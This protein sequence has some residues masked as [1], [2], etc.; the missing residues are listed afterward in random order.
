MEGRLEYGENKTHLK[1]SEK[2]EWYVNRLDDFH[3]YEYDFNLWQEYT[4][5]WFEQESEPMTAEELMEELEEEEEN[6]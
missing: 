3:I 5:G 2:A 6:G 4:Y 1:L